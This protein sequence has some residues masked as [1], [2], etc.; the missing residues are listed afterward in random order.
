MKTFILSLLFVLP[1]TSFASENTNFV[2]DK[3]MAEIDV[4]GDEVFKEKLYK[5]RSEVSQGGI[6]LNLV[7]N[8]YLLNKELPK[9]ELMYPYK[10]QSFQESIEAQIKTPDNSSLAMITTIIGQCIYGPMISKAVLEACSKDKLFNR[11]NELSDIYDTGAW[12][13]ILQDL[14]SVLDIVR[15]NKIQILAMHESIAKMSE[16]EVTK[17][18]NPGAPATQNT[19]KKPEVTKEAN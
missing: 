5:S 7:I 19:T 12:A 2:S 8:S 11:V 13:T 16:V 9:S 18:Q 4:Y 10:N 14:Y 15:A 17:D 1:I 6:E 3:L